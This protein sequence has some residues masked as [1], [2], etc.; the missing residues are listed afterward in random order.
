MR[1]FLGSASFSGQKSALQAAALQKE[2]ERAERA[3]KLA[4]N[5]Q[6][7]VD[8][9]ISARKKYVSTLAA[10]DRAV[11][12]HRKEAEAAKATL[13][14]HISKHQVLLREHDAMLA[15]HKA[16]IE[17]MKQDYS[18]K[19]RAQARQHRQQLRDALAT[20]QTGES[21]HEA[22]ENLLRNARSGLRQVVGSGRSTRTRTSKSI[23][24]K[25]A[26]SLSHE[27]SE[28]THPASPERL[29]ALDQARFAIR[30]VRK[31]HALEDEAAWA[32]MEARAAATAQ[33]AAERRA[34]AARAQRLE[35]Y[36][37]TFGHGAAHR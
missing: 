5:L 34:Q 33:R 10:R 28:P 11:E 16:E 13:D 15:S 1:S 32:E 12:R 3:E 8:G 20:A 27:P 18:Q 25:A 31:Q 36:R 26:Y 30:R 4:E 2:R 29:H 37:R 6:R 22:H 21:R 19:Y 35:H 24:I 14:R 9:H 7:Q 23:S 17:R